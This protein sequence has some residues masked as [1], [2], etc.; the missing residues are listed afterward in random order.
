MM[1]ISLGCEV[2]KAVFTT[3]RPLFGLAHEP[4]L[5]P[6]FMRGSS[7]ARYK[8]SLIHPRFKRGPALRDRGKQHDL[9]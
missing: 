9:A 8:R 4:V 1:D 6:P 7:F 3:M 2:D 5:K